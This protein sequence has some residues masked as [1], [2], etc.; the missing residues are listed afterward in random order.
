MN[1]AWELLLLLFSSLFHRHFTFHAMFVSFFH[2]DFFYPCF[3]IRTHFSYLNKL[4]SW[5]YYVYATE[6]K[7]AFTSFKNVVPFPI[8]GGLVVIYLGNVIQPVSL[9]FC[10][11]FTPLFDH[12]YLKK[13]KN[14]VIKIHRPSHDISL[15]LHIEFATLF[16]NDL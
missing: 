12:F 3:A 7:P 10:I 15:W 8:M 5:G 11:G 13:K 6:I 2:F 16:I 9:T 4:T 1:L 14:L